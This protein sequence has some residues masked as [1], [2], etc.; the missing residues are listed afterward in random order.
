MA[1]DTSFQSWPAKGIRFKTRYTELAQKLLHEIATTGMQ[2]GQKLGTEGE[3]ALKHSVSRVT[4][5]AALSILEQG[6]YI[7]RRKALGTFI[8]RSAQPQPFSGSRKGTIVFVC[9]SD[10]PTHPY[11]NFGF[12]TMLRTIERV[13][14][15]EGF[16]L[17]IVGLESD[18]GVNRRRLHDLVGQP[19]VRGFCFVPIW[20]VSLDEYEEYLS[21]L[22]AGTPSV[23]CNGYDLGL[24]TCVARAMDTGCRELVDLLL[25]N[26]HR[27]IAMLISPMFSPQE[28][29]IHASSYTAAFE[30]RGLSV[31]R[32]LIYK[33]YR[34]E[35]LN[36]LVRG[37]LTSRI[38]PTAVV[39]SD[40]RICE[41]VLSTAHELGLS[42]PADL[43]VVGYGDNVLHVQGRVAVTA[44]AVQNERLAENAV[45]LLIGFINN[46]PDVSQT[47]VVPGKL[48]EGGSV[49]RL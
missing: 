35:P 20:S 44:Y 8:K 21:W 37:A 3:L 41:A 13:L 14:R 45:R 18:S 32:C 34:G 31:E 28:Y 46:N 6:G 30:A 29:S 15:E 27:D 26:G 40:A 7:D 22:P 39:C 10:E 38:R 9:R 2:P 24:P 48:I 1:L 36:R 12:V 25:A 19:E 11:E 23:L 4:V 49:Q 42:I 5:R 16:N 33:G 43:S 47:L 17:Q